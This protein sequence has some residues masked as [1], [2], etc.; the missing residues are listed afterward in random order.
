MMQFFTFFS[1]F[2]HTV[3]TDS[4]I[5]HIDI[6]VGV[7]LITMDIKISTHYISGSYAISFNYGFIITKC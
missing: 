4:K 5:T 3:M 6:T 1:N 7:K 2:F